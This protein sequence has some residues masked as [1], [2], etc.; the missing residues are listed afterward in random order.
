MQRGNYTLPRIQGLWDQTPVSHKR[1]TLSPKISSTLESSHRSDLQNFN[2]ST[3]PSVTDMQMRRDPDIPLP[4]G[5]T[6]PDYNMQMPF[7]GQGVPDLSAMMFPSAD[8]FAYPNQ[9][10]TTLENRNFVKQ[11]NNLVSSSYNPPISNASGTDVQQV[12]MDAQMFS[13]MPPYTMPGQ[14]SGYMQNINP[15]ISTNN[16]IP[17]ASSTATQVDGIGRWPLQDQRQNEQMAGINYDQLFGEDWGGWMN[18]R[19]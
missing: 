12:N 11:E 4:L 7:S 6:Q 17:A 16:E 18:Y 8:P 14:Q 5:V 3:K 13:Q 9:P 15:S 10:M 19:Q 1:S 2:V